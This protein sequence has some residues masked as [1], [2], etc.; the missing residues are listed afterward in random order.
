MLCLTCNTDNAPQRL[1]CSKCG[2]KLNAIR[3]ICGFVNQES[4][5][6]CGGCGI[7]LKE[8]EEK[9]GVDIKVKNVIGTTTELLTEEDIKNILDECSLRFTSRKA[10]LTQQEIEKLFKS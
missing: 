3:H 2:S 4:D 7:Q 1:Y 6:Y 9:L 8:S 10:S 5:I